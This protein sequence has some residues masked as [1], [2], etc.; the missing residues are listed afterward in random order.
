MNLLQARV[1]VSQDI[2]LL[3]LSCLENPVFRKSA[4]SELMFNTVKLD[5]LKKHQHVMIDLSLVES[6]VPGELKLGE[7]SFQVSF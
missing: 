5:D 6:Q 3:N 7:Q 1:S 2:P 4:S